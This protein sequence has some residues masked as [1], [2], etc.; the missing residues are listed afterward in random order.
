MGVKPWKNSWLCAS[1][2]FVFFLR[3][4]ICFQTPSIPGAIM[5]QLRGPPPR[6]NVSLLIGLNAPMDLVLLG[7]GPF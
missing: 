2:L 7:G 4:M 1:L 3:P 6:S 5:V